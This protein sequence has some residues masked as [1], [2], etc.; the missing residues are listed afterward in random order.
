MSV[1][2][3]EKR[4]TAHGL[5]AGDVGTPATLG[6]FAR[7][8]QKKGLYCLHPIMYVERRMMVEH[9]DRLAPERP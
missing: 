8:N 2:R 4:E 7:S 5:R 3:N 9:L 1:I 6:S